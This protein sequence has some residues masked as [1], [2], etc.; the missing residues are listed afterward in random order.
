MPPNMR[1]DDWDRLFAPNAP[2]RGGPLRVLVTILLTLGTIGL[3]AFGVRYGLAYREQQFAAASATATVSAATAYPART[4]TALAQAQA[5]AAQA[6]QR[7]AA[8]VTSLPTPEPALGEGVVVRGGNMRKE[9]RIAA[10]TLL[11]LIWPGDQVRF[12]ERR[13]VG[14]QAWFRIRVLKPADNRGGEGVAAGVDGWAAESLLSQPTPV[15]TP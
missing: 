15:A 2:R 10:E 14:G 7:T 8:A 9:P 1:T 5:T 11:G 12:L 6:A 13:D 3:L 4:A